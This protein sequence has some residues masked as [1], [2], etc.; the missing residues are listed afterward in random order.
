MT[1][2]EKTVIVQRLCEGPLY[3][4]ALRRYLYVVWGSET[5]ASETHRQIDALIKERLVEILPDGRLTTAGGADVAQRAG[6]GKP[7][8][9]NGRLP[10]QKLGQTLERHAQAVAD[11]V[12]VIAGQE[13]TQQPIGNGAQVRAI[14][15][16]QLPE[17]H[18]V[19]RL[20]SGEE[21]VVVRRWSLRY[22]H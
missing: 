21:A 20:G 19:S 18:R 14:T 11:H 22:T 7:A 9:E 5:R 8:Q 4:W 2:D 10:V 3:F 12:G 16:G 6:E 15:L 1:F 13:V 17:R